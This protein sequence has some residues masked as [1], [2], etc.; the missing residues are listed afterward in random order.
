MRGCSDVSLESYVAKHVKSLGPI[1][2]L[3][4]D[5]EGWDFDVLFGAG[6]VLDRT[7][8]IEFEYSDIGHV[9]VL[10]HATLSPLV[11]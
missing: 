7:K 3:Q 2:V 6:S 1:D 8:Y 11:Q 5:V 10:L 4:I 9:S